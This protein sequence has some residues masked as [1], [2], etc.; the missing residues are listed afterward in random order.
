VASVIQTIPALALLAA[1]VPALG[2]LGLPAIGTLPALIGLCL[3]GVLPILRNVV[4][5]IAGVDPAVREAARAVGMTSGQQLRIVELPLAAPV[6][7]AG[8][9]TAAVWLVGMATLSTPVG[10]PSLGNY[11]FGGLQTRRYESVLLGCVAAAALAMVLD[12]VIRALETG[13]R[14]RRVWRTRLAA[15]MLAIV[16]LVAAGSAAGFGS[17]SRPGPRSGPASTPG[18]ITIGAKTFTEQFI[19]AELLSLHLQRETHAGTRVLSSLGSTV[20]Y[21]ALRQ[22]EIDLYVDY[23]GTLWTTI[24][25]RTGPT[26]SRDRMLAELRRE[27][28]HRDGIEIPAALGFENAYALA[29]RERQAAEL[30]ITTLSDLT[31]HAPQLVFGGDYEF[32]QR[33]EWSDLRRIYGLTPRDQRTMDPSLMYQAAAEGEVDVISAYST[34]GRIP[35]LQLRVLTDDRNAIPPY[36]AVILVS[37]RFTQR[38]PHALSALRALEGRI[39]DAAMSRMN[40]Q[41]DRDHRTPRAVAEDFL[42]P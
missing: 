4:T 23:T 1:M 6:I 31:P 2:A 11:I 37:R 39:D 42:R 25:Q 22:G 7:V 15:A 36:D 26:P 20:V 33:Q 29:M 35:A 27:L 34:D 12:G 32:F 9:R 18:E 14:Q 40:M 21:D 30:S 3:Y 17:G 5:G 16:V 10:A 38:H 24:L 41:V 19:L 28:R 8:V 13:V